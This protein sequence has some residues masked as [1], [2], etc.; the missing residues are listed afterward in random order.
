LD[1]PDHPDEKFGPAGKQ[2]LAPSGGTYGYDLMFKTT[3]LRFFDCQLLE[4]IQQSYRQ[5]TGRLIPTRTL[6]DLSKKTLVRIELI[7]DKSGPRIKNVLDEQ[8]GYILMLDST[9]EDEPPFLFMAMDGISGIILDRDYVPSESEDNIVATLERI[10]T[11]Y[12]LPLAVV[13]D[14]SDG[15]IKAIS[16][17]FPGIPQVS[18]QYHVLKNV[19]KALFVDLYA[20]LVSTMEKLRVVPAIARLCRSLEPAIESMPDRN[21]KCAQILYEKTLP[22]LAV[23][24]LLPL[25]TYAI[26]SW[27]L[28]TKSKAEKMPY[29]FELPYLEFFKGSEKALPMT[30][31]FVSNLGGA[32][33]QYKPINEL[34][35]LL[36]RVVNDETIVRQVNLLKRLSEVF[37]QIRR[38][39][40]LPQGT[41]LLK[42]APTWNQQTTSDVRSS[43]ASFLDKLEATISTLDREGERRKRCEKVIA[44]LRKEFDGLFVPNPIVIRN[45]KPTEIAL[46]RTN[47]LLERTFWKILRVLTR[48]KSRKRVKQGLHLYGRSIAILLNL[49]N[50]AYIRSVYPD[51]ILIRLAEEENP[52]GVASTPY[53]IPQ[54]IKIPGKIPFEHVL[55]FANRALPVIQ[56]ALD[57]PYDTPPP[58]HLPR[59][60]GAA[61]GLL[62]P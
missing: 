54:D 26:G 16:H 60:A 47:N 3:L 45:D 46:P 61:N 25:V 21:R 10:K 8:G 49:K 42:N 13:R 5:I 35:T 44:M 12:G 9:F 38:I 31:R 6:C 11:K 36:K 4:Q 48:L 57:L 59:V 40:R 29:P 15:L 32:F 24:E 39:L 20:E 41:D 43:L 7:H 1:C 30:H 14:G 52:S 62:P 37:H 51:G 28:K 53:G 22:P 33:R 19:G 27:L 50:S 34:E 17:V 18:C 23:E 2:L 58:L 56:R 55:D